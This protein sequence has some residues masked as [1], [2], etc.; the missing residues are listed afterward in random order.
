MKYSLIVISVLLVF[1]I[2]CSANSPSYRRNSNWQDSINYKVYKIDSIN[3]YHLIYANQGRKLFK[4]IVKKEQVK[5]GKKIIVNSS[6]PFHL[7]SILYAN[8]NALIPGNQI[9]ELSGW[10]ID[11]STTIKFEGDS[12]RDLY[13][14]DNI[15]GLYFI[16]KAK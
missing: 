11:D 4:I 6:Y 16:K 15:R 7:Q 2:R 9:M 5:R 14:A 12:I 3:N 8:G 1:G 13:N 10:R